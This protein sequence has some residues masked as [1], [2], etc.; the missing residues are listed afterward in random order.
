M[1]IARSSFFYSPLPVRGE[2]GKM[3]ATSI[4]TI[5]RTGKGKKERGKPV[6]SRTKRPAPA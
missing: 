3:L 4:S 2:K 1:A 5:T 6:A